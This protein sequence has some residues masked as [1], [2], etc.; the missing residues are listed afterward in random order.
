M[1]KISQR[2][3]IVKENYNSADSEKFIDE[4]YKKQNTKYFLYC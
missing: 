2:S 3:C 1:K 4:Y